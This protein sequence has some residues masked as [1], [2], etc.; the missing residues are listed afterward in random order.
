MPL[1]RDVATVGSATLGSR[2]LGFV[3]DIG[4]AAL[5]G[6]G[7][8]SDAFFAVFQFVNFFRRLLAEG[9]AQCGLRPDVAALQAVDRQERRRCLSRQ[10][11]RHDPG[12]D[13]R[14]GS[15]RVLARPR[16]GWRDACS[17]WPAV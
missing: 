7:S 1:A 10:Y 16:H 15:N 6:A 13:R 12:G 11:V 4:V 3:R 17:P 2:L 9:R 14:A 8:L 5:L